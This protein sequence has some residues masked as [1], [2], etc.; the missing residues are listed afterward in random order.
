V[1]AD[2]PSVEPVQLTSAPDYIAV[3]TAALA[4]AAKFWADSKHTDAEQVLDTAAAWTSWVLA[5][6]TQ[7]V[8]TAA[9]V[10][11]DQHDPAKNNPTISVPA[12]GGAGTMA[13]TMTDTQ[14][15]T[16]SVKPE[17]SKGA[18]TTGDTVTWSEDS[19]GAVVTLQPSADGLS[20]VVVAN[21]PGTAN[22]TATD[23]T[24]TGTDTIT[25]DPGATSQL[26]L[27]EG[28]VTDQAPPT[29]GA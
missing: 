5:P 4:A 2:I 8:I 20:C 27:S 26:A 3:R 17:D 15:V 21:A 18:P 9:P 13:V 23:G 16:L 25:V 28:P 11:F 24:L 12:P 22:V 7:L 19:S 10:T 14:Q 1:A 6:A 29:P